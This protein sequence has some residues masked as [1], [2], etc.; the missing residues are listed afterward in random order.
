VRRII[1]IVERENLQQ[2]GDFLFRNVSSLKQRL[3]HILYYNYYK[4]E[5]YTIED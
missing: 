5:K 3:N 4:I 2:A 1:A